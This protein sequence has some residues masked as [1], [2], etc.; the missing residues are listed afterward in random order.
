[1][2]AQEKSCPTRSSDTQRAT[3][4]S[5]QTIAGQLLELVR[6]TIYASL[7]TDILCITRTVSF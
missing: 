1:M 7:F 3:A 6:M 2:P 5:L 4:N